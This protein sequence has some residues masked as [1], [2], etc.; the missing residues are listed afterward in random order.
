MDKLKSQDQ[1]FAKMVERH[2]FLDERLKQLSGKIR[3]D[4][5]EETEERTLKREK[6]RLRDRIE[7]TL[8]IHRN[9]VLPA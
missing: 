7:E 3:L 9:I 4:A 1:D 2:Q 8:R 6:L 5:E